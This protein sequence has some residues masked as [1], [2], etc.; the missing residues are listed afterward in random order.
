MERLA[1][2]SFA[3]ETDVKGLPPT[4]INVNECD[5]VRD[6]GVNFYRLLLAADL[7]RF[8]RG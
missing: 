8:A 7:A 4:I 5:P 1:R 6:E 3:T 2:P